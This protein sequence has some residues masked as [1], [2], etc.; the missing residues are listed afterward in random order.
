MDV[1]TRIFERLALLTQGERLYAVLD[2][3]RDPRVRALLQSANLPHQSLYDGA[4][5]EALA[6][7]SPYLVALSG[8]DPASR[9]VVAAAWGGAWGCFIVT[10]LASPKLRSHLRRFLRVKTEQG[11]TLVFRFYDPRVLGTYLSTCT[12]QELREFF[13]P[14]STFAMEDRTGSHLLAFSVNGHTFSASRIALTESP[15]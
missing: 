4:L 8:D 5:P 1:A 7:V 12:E 3:A 6:D 11:K 13:G 10:S 9:R 14:I 15:N 2:G